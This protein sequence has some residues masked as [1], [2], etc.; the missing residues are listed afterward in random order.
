M[1]FYMIDN[2][3]SFVYNLVSY[4]EKLGQEVLVENI[5]SI[6]IEKL[7]IS[8]L[9]GIIISPGPG[10]P[11]QAAV[12]KKAIQL[13]GGRL[14]ILGVCLGHQVI[15]HSFGG[16][17]IKGKRPMHGKI[18]KL[19][20]NG[21]RLFKNLPDRFFVTRYH[22]LVVDMSKLP[23]DFMIDATSADGEVMAISHQKQPVYGV[24]FH[25][26]ALL[27]EY[28]YEILNNFISICEKW[29]MVTCIK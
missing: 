21:L 19:S 9:G 13:Y 17:V 14:P 24:Q 25:P 15:A 27:T 5:K 26:E 1:K 10:T 7:D 8:G 23:A 2:N 18:S 4:F 16:S 3:D 22:S 29:R 11:E 12:S 20:N 6:S 28:G